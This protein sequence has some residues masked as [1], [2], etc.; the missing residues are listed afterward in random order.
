MNNKIVLICV[1][2]ALAVALTA[3]LVVVGIG[4]RNMHQPDN[5]TG[6]QPSTQSPDVSTGE[7][8]TADTTDTTTNPTENETTVGDETVPEQPTQGAADNTEPTK[9]DSSQ[10]AEGFGAHQPGSTES[11]TKPTSKPQPTEPSKPPVITEDG[12]ET[13][14]FNGKTLEEFT[15]M[16]YINMDVE[17]E[18]PAFIAWATEQLGSRRAFNQWLDKVYDEKEQKQT[19][20]VL[21]NG[22]SLDLGELLNK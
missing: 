9:P 6:S 7:N 14:T 17:V 20:V 15:Y 22:N 11:T 3:A 8:T 13:P 10:D 4:E 2:A 21:G 16:E 19:H 18:Q 1:I 12:E 5:T